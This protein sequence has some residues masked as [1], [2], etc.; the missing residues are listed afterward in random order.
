MIR[1]SRLAFFFDSAA[2]QKGNKVCERIGIVERVSNGW[3]HIVL[4]ILE[5]HLVRIR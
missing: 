4:L 3:C 5:A 1:S 2:E